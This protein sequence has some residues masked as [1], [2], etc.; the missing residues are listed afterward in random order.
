M[1]SSAVGKYKFW[2]ETAMKTKLMVGLMMCA[3]ACFATSGK[4]EKAEKPEKPEKI[5][6]IEKKEKVGYTQLA[7]GHHG[8]KPRRPGHGV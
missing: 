3:L 4:P 1:I 6:K 2:R 5:E 8:G 7:E